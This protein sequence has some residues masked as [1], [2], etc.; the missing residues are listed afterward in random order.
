[1]GLEN[2]KVAA[3]LCFRVSLELDTS[4]FM[5]LFPSDLSALIFVFQEP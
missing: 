3:T 1:M 4:I 5:L 2:A